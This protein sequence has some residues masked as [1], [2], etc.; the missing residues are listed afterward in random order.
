MGLD[1]LEDEKEDDK[2]EALVAEAN[3]AKWTARKGIGGRGVY[4]GGGRGGGD[5][6]R[7]RSDDGRGGGSRSGGGAEDTRACFACG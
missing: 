3:Y 7:G 2:V 1:E 5:G 4:R 6:G